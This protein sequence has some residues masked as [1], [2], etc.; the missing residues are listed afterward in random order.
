MRK[1]LIHYLVLTFVVAAFA[2]VPATSFAHDKRGSPGAKVD[3]SQKYDQIKE[4]KMK[5]MVEELNLTEEQQ[6]KI[7]AIQENQKDDF[8]AK[9]KAAHQARRALKDAMQGDATDDDLRK[10]YDASQKAK[11][12][13]SKTRFEQVLSIRAVLTPEQKKKFKGFRRHRKGEKGKHPKDPKPN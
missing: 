13:F 8:I 2:T 11:A 3:L 5:R 1:Y 6:K 9:K 7:K 12:D 10:L 4:R